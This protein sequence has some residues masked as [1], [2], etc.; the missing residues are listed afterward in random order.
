MHRNKRTELGDPKFQDDPE[1]IKKLVQNLTSYEYAGTFLD[2]ITNV[3]HDYKYYDPTFSLPDDAGTS[4]MSI[5]DQ[6]I[7]LE[8]SC[9]YEL[10]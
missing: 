7:K 8:V 4:H 9:K 1:I 2:R 5:V 3:T 6:G 10:R